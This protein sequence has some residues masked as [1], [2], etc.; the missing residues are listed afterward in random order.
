MLCETQ[1]TKTEVVM[2]RHAQSEWN[3]AGL[4]TGWADPALTL[5]GYR[6]ALMAAEALMAMGNMTVQEI[7]AFEIPTG[8]PIVDAFSEE[9]MPIGWRYLGAKEPKAA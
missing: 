6:E 4:F 1:K 9:G 3:R 7:E 5:A 8:I 2:I